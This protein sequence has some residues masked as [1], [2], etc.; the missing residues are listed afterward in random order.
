MSDEAGMTDGVADSLREGKGDQLTTANRD[1]AATTAT[2]ERWLSQVAGLEDVAVSNL[3]IPGSTGWSNETILFDASWREAGRRTDHELVA[4]IA[5]TG[6]TVF[7]GRTFAAQFEVMRA[8]A[9]EGSV[10]MATIHWLEPSTDWFDSEF[11]IMDRIRG[12]IPSDAPAY[13]AT[14]WLHDATPADQARA[15]WAGVDAMAAIHRLDVDRLALTTTTVA[16]G[17][18][19]LTAQLDHYEHFLT[20]AEDGHPSALARRALSWLRDNAA[21]P[22]EQGPTL[23]WGD[24]R[25]SNLIYRHFEVVAVLDWEMS[26]IADPLLDL[27]WWIFSDDA[28]TRGSGQVRL[29]GF[30]STSETAARWSELTGRSTDALAYYEVMG[31]FRFTVIMLR[32]GKLLHD[33]GLVDEGFAHDNL[34]SQALAERLNSL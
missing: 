17:P 27:G 11:W 28:L 30:P 9:D 13:S 24:A 5:P 6:Y 20:W 1:P 18:D 14:G 31:A 26:S 12:D 32:M 16:P 21:D 33:I 15:W 2:L 8:L 4:R 29:P 19:P 3:A 34:I 23:T 10:P 7:P 25:F 22:P